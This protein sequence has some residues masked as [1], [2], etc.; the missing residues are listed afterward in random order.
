MS[1]H[2]PNVRLARPLI[3]STP[4]A[5]L[6]LALGLALSGCEDSVAVTPPPAR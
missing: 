5:A 2:T 4:V 3:L 1:R 6:V